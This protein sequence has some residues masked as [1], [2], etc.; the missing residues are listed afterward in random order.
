MKTVL[1]QL[2]SMKVSIVLMLIFALACACA[3]FIENDFGTQ[4]AWAVIYASWWFALIQLWLGFCIIYNIFKYKLFQTNKIPSLIFHMSFLFILLGSGLT[5]YFGF[6]GSIHIREGESQNIVTSSASF[7]SIKAKKDAKTYKLSKEKLFSSFGSNSLNLTLDVAGHEA[8]FHAKELLV[9]AVQKILPDPNGKPIVSLMISDQHTRAAE[10]NLKNGENIDNGYIWVDFN[11]TST[12]TPN[13]FHISLEDGKFYFIS[14]QKVQW[15]KMATNEKGE[16]KANQKY[17]FIAKQLYTIAGVNIAVKGMFAKAKQKW[18]SKPHEISNVNYKVLVGDLTYEGVT[19]EVALIGYGKGSKGMDTKAHIKGVDFTLNWGA[20]LF[21]LPFKLK[22]V[23]FQL[24]R[25][26]GSMSPS[27]YA[28]EV[29][30]VDKKDHINIPYR[31]YMNHVLDFKGFRFFQ[32]SYDK[33][34][35]GTILSVN[36]DPG[37]WPTY[38]GYFLLSLGLFLNMLNPKSRFRKLALDI[39]KNMAIKSLVFISFV[40]MQTTQLKANDIPNAIEKQHADYFG[41]ILVQSGDGRIKPIDSVAHDVLNKVYRKYHFKN[42]DANQV[43]LG[44]V[45]MPHIWQQQPMIKVYD[46]KIKKIIGIKSSQKYASFNDFFNTSKNR[47]YKLLKYIEQAN[48]KRPALRDQFD[49]D[50]IKVDERVN[51][52]YYVYT[53][54]I[55]KM[56][57]KVGDKNK[58][59][60]GSNSAIMYFSKNESDDI[61]NILSSY[62]QAVEKGLRTG[63]YSGADESVKKIKSYQIQYANDIIPSQSKINTEI[64]FNHYRIFQKLTPVYLVAGLVLLF[65]IFF[66]MLFPNLGIKWLSKIVLWVIILSFIINTVGLGMRWYISGHAPWSD[67]YES[68]VYIAWALALAGIVFSRQSPISLA[69]TSILSGVSLFVAHLS[70]IDPQITTL[71][72]V[73][74]SYWLTIHVSIITASYGFLGLC[75]L[76]GFFTLLLFIVKNPKNSTKRDKEISKNITEASKINEM[77]M[78]FGLSLLVVGN[79][80]GGVWANESWGRYWGWDAKETWAL[81]SILIYAA[82]AH[83]RFIPK[84]NNQYAFAVASMFAFWSIIMTYFGVNFYLS[85]MHSYASGDPVPI[86]LFVPVIAAI[87]LLISIV[88]F[89]KRSFATKL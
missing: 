50:V 27:S 19:K 38:F 35:L 60:Y 47:S 54:E 69:L 57:P 58:K 32:S 9:N 5:R 2:F 63:D 43:L 18:V 10:I 44:M 77:S 16:Y 59:W 65:A 86:P 24:D 26:P 14:N 41:T 52:C 40:L 1:K 55:L 30:V 6:E 64:N 88:A 53:G 56:F 78:I 31:I 7:V 49:K 73:L 81:I 39:N 46:E 51:V 71:V 29:E 11:K 62:F 70:W 83:M 3:T 8:T 76:L 72:P 45:M 17:P 79:F 33:D 61:K 34:E 75:G 89:F 66:K 15:F 20:K 84:L 25:Y 87:M 80:L 22:L 21:V 42:L 36:N 23:D 74:K 4:S 13:Q 67:G 85:G 28:S 37:K 68:M 12:T 82:V 48:R